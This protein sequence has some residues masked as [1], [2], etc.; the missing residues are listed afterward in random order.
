[1]AEGLMR[2]ELAQRRCHD[3]EVAS[4]GTWAG[5]GHPATPEAISAAAALGVDIASH[6]SRPLEADELRRADLIVAMTSVHVKEIL[7]VA[8][9]AAS[10]LVLLKQLAETDVR[11]GPPNAPPRERLRV[12]LS[13]RRPELR[14]AH[15]LDDPIGLGLPAYERCLS[16]LRVGIDQLADSLCGRS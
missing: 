3:V 6:R 5:F 8:P 13:A 16:E 11:K 4:A 12:L 2:H 1:M 7:N 9:E 10:K 14:R 15:D